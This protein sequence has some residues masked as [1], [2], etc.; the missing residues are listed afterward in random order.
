MRLSANP[1]RFAYGRQNAACR[2]R[3]LYPNPIAVSDSN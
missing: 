1:D 3:T 2:D